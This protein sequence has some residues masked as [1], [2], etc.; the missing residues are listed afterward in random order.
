MRDPGA[1][2]S[3]D[4]RFDRDRGWE[5]RSEPPKPWTVDLDGLTFDL[6]PTDSGQVGIF[7]EQAANWR[8]VRDVVR[9]GHEVLNLFAYTG[10]ATLAAVA[11]GSRVVHVDSSRPVVNWARRNA[12]LSGLD[13]RPI[14]W[15][16]DDADAFVER[17][18]RR[19]RLYDGIV[20]DPPTYGHGR[21]GAVWRLDDQLPAFLDACARLTRPDA[22]VILTA[23]AADSDGHRL[24]NELSA[25]FGA[26]RRVETEEL[27]LTATSGARLWLGS[28]ARIMPGR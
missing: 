4:L 27:V 19:G 9:P 16:V 3:A 23:H 12:E 17:E 15:I 25:A 11:A 28:C 24:A 2:A 6:R 18:I 1:W 13:N 14:R 21:G 7:P 8:F 5:V 10:G 22:F 20:L 26:D